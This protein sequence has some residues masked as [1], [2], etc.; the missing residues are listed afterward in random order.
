LPVLSHSVLAL[1]VKKNAPADVL[2][3]ALDKFA[4]TYQLFV[5]MHTRWKETLEISTFW[6]SIYL[7]YSYTWC[8]T[9]SYITI[10]SPYIVCIK[11]LHIIWN[12]LYNI[13]TWF[14]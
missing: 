14:N 8:I 11:L 12:F 1:N 9:P 2:C 13:R 10:P 4:C 3:F 5:S 7:Q 6:V